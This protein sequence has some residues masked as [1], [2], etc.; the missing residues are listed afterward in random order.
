MKAL[1][2]VEM[3][4]LA[5]RRAL[6]ALAG[7]A[8]IGITV[9]AVVAFVQ[10]GTAGEPPFRWAAM[11]EILLGLAPILLTIGWV[12]GA[13][14]MGAEWGSKIITTQLTW[15]PRRV[16]LFV[17]KAVATAVTVFLFVVGVQ[18]FLA[19]ALSPVAAVHGTFDGVTRTWGFE[20][21]GEI[22]R[23]ALTAALMSMLAFAIA[24]V[25]RN[26]AAAIGVGFVYLAVIEGLIRG[27]KPEWVPWL[28]GD[29]S[30]T[31]VVGGGTDSPIL[32]RSAA[33]A[34]LALAV[35]AATFIA[36]AGMTF[37]RRDVT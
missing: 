22:W 17:V 30:V 6:R 3:W 13:T 25:G 31:L 37:V 27:L 26:T 21:A 4:R 16:R 20:V 35:Y 15:E 11:D 23:V 12:I 10:T 18:L 28:I 36:S 14:A 29:N 9:G 19:A 24:A 5:S 34:A 8:V 32:G 2:E 1:I 33:V 7:V